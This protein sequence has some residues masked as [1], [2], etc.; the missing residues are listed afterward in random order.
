MRFLRSLLFLI[1]QIVYTG[2]YALV[3]TVSYPFMSSVDARYRLARGWCVSMIAVA[4]WLLGIDYRV[5]GMENLPDGPAVVLAKHQS[6]WETMAIPMLMPR[7]LCYI[8]KRELLY[9]PLFGQAIGGLGMIAINRKDGKKSFDSMIS[10]GKK[11]L[12]EGAWVMM[13]PEGTRTPRGAVTKYKSGGARFA[14]GTGAP[15]IPIAHNAGHLWPRK[16]FTKRPGTV[17]VSIG[18]P[19]SP[20]GLSAD[21]MLARVEHWIETEMR[22]IDPDGYTGDAREVPSVESMTERSRSRS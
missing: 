18:K 3:C 12:S 20:E 6:A 4:R 14:V 21:E 2:V 17:T 19:I 13:F 5:E 9:I 16:A 11:R 1:F 10:Q 8:F 7:T 15:V 22:R